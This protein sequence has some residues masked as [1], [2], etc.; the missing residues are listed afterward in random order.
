MIIVLNIILKL[1]KKSPLTSVPPTITTS[2][3]SNNL[4]LLLTADELRFAI[5]LRLNCEI[6][7]PYQ[8]KHCET[9]VDRKGRHCLHCRF[10]R[11]RFPRHTNCND[12]ILR[13]LKSA[14]IPSRLEPT[15]IFRSDGK[16]PDGMSLIP[17]SRGQLLVWDFTCIDPNAPSNHNVDALALA[18]TRKTIKY[19]SIDPSFLFIPIACSTLNHLR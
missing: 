19:S 16:R 10:C 12:I 15:G 8:C 14:G 11:G 13:A 4:D 1:I 18:E 2:N 7:L 17:W 6:V 5:G 3:F 9:S